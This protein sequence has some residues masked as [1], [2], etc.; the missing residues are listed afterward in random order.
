MT[1][2]KENCVDFLK[3]VAEQ[4]PSRLGALPLQIGN[5]RFA[6]ISFEETDVEVVKS[7]L[8]TGLKFNDGAVVLPCRALGTDMEVISVRLSNLP[9]F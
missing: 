7:F 2:R 8:T 6:E 4:Y 9:F 1:G 3:L 5:L